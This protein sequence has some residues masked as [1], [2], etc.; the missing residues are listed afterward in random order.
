MMSV[1]FIA[2]AKKCYLCHA[3]VVRLCCLYHVPLYSENVVCTI[4]AAAVPVL[5][6]SDNA[7]CTMHCFC[8]TIAPLPCLEFVRQCYLHHHCCFLTTSLP[9]IEFVKRCRMY[10]HFCCKTVLSV[11]CTC[12]AFVRQYCLYHDHSGQPMLSVLVPSLFSSASASVCVCCCQT[13]LSIPC[14]SFARQCCLYKRTV[15]ARQSSLYCA[16]WFFRQC[17]LHH[18]CC[19]QTVLL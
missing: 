11:P 16:L 19:C 7:L 18:H 14:T 3:H 9:C 4:T 17:C 1:S 6:F 12:T 5:T 2:V 15:V 13:V 10:R 8:Q